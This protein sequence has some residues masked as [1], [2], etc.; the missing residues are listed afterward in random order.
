MRK[1]K[2]HRKLFTGNRDCFGKRGSWQ[3][4]MRSDFALH[5]A[6][7]KLLSL[8]ISESRPRSD[9]IVGNDVLHS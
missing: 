9:F 7:Q 6:G 1:V 8:V 2:P 5:V 3:L 4:R